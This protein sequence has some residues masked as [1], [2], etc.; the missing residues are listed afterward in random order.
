MHRS[1]LIASA[2]LAVSASVHANPVLVEVRVE[3]L[4]PTNSVAFAGL[5]FGFHNGTFDSFNEGQSVFLLG[6]PTVA[7]A[8]IISIAEGGTAST[9][10]PAFAAA[11]PNATFGS[12]LRNGP[13]ALRPG[14]MSF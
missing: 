12:V 5:R 2:T 6:Q 10:F 1:I 14:E 9:W 7:T 3:N 8:P 13:G 4:A 11:E